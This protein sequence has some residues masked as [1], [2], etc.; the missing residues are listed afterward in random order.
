MEAGK[1]FTRLFYT[2]GSD[3]CTNT[4]SHGVGVGV[5]GQSGGG[6]GVGAR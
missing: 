2:F 6:V 5:A 1:F 3:M 4:V